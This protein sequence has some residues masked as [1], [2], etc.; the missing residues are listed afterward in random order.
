MEQEVLVSHQLGVYKNDMWL[1]TFNFLNTKGEKVSLSGL[2]VKIIVNFFATWCGPC[3][4]ENAYSCS[5]RQ[6]N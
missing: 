1:K 2:E 4:E 6:K 3:Q 5:L